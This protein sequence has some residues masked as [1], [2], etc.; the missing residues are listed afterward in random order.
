MDLTEWLYVD[1]AEKQHESSDGHHRR[2]D[3]LKV[4]FL[5][6]FPEF[7]CKYIP[8]FGVFVAQI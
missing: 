5:H 3:Y 6:D 4:E 8:D 1:A 2:S 7:E